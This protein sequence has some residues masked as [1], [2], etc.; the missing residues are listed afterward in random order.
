MSGCWGDLQACQ[1][2]PGSHR[3][4]PLL[5][6]R[7]GRQHSQPSC[8]GSTDHALSCASC[9]PCL[10]CHLQRTRCA[11]SGPYLRL[12]EL[13]VPTRPSAVVYEGHLV[14]IWYSERP[15]LRAR[16]CLG[17]RT[18]PVNRPAFAFTPLHWSQRRRQ[19]DKSSRSPPARGAFGLRRLGCGQIR[20]EDT[21][22]ARPDT[23]RSA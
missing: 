9:P 20:L 2:I 22:S 10:T 16:R 3:R 1:M 14:Q 5:V 21:H 15:R 17:L 4:M 13:N 8:A 19:G 23:A 11:A 7:Q 6:P 18:V 12:S